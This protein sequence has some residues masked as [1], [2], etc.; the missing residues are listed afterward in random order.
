MSIPKLYRVG[1]ASLVQDE[2][3][4]KLVLYVLRTDELFIQLATLDQDDP[5]GQVWSTVF[6]HHQLPPCPWIVQGNVW[7]SL[8]VYIFV[9]KLVPHVMI[10][11]VRNQVDLSDRRACHMSSI[12]LL[13]RF[14]CQGSLSINSRIPPLPSSFLKFPSS[15][16]FVLD[17]HLEVSC[18]YSLPSFQIQVFSLSSS[19]AFKLS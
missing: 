11:L 5:Y 2:L 12:D 14:R 16:S 7:L 15:S 18:V 17:P 9:S 19:L 8:N 6:Q 3:Y 13:C 4:M 10:S 1:L